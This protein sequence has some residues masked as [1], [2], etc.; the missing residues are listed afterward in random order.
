MK[1]LLNVDY[2]NGHQFSD[3]VVLSKAI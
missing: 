3:E 2:E 1:K